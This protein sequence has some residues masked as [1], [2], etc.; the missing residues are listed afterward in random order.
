[1][2]DHVDKIGFFLRNV[3]RSNKSGHGNHNYNPEGELLSDFLEREAF[4]HDSSNNMS[5]TTMDRMQV[6]PEEDGL[7]LQEIQEEGKITHTQQSTVSGSHSTSNSDDA[8]EEKEKILR[9]P[10][11][12]I[13][14]LE[15]ITEKLPSWQS[16]I[17]Q[18][19]FL[20]TSICSFVADWFYSI[21]IGILVTT[22]WR[23]SNFFTDLQIQES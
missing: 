10:P 19:G 3:L 16:I 1:M 11:G 20:G 5:S 7:E 12:K 22:Y 6:V 9:G 15:I 8:D 13:E 2:E 23:V 18:K 14:P 4:L 21:L 17:E